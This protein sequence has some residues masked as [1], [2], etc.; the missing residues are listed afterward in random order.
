MKSLLIF[1]F[2]GTYVLNINAQEFQRFSIEPDFHMKFSLGAQKRK[3]IDYQPGLTINIPEQS[4]YSGPVSG[5]GFC[6][7]YHY[8]KKLTAGVGSGIDIVKFEKHPIAIDEYYD[9]ITIP[10][11]LKIGYQR[12]LSN[13]WLLLSDVHSGYQFLDFRYGNTQEGFLYQE[14]GGLMVN[15]NLGIG[16]QVG[17]YLPIVK[18]GYEFNQ[19]SNEFSLGTL[20]GLELDYDDKVYYKTYY[21]LLKASLSIKI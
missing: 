16:K 13:S 17:K 14:S 2:V 7:N 1:L 10:F 5:I 15:V 18:L 4:E 3:T 12:E 21:H 19:F 20:P 6:L 8:S 9:R 11:F